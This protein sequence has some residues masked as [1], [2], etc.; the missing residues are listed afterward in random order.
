MRIATICNLPPPFGG[1]E[2][3]AKQLA[4]YLSKEGEEI[5]I[6]TQK[7]FEMELVDGLDIFR[8]PYASEQQFNIAQQGIKIYPLF[9][10]SF[11]RK[12]L[13]ENIETIDEQL[14]QRLEEVFCREKPDV[15][16]CH[17]TTGK[18]KKVLRVCRKM[19]IPL[20][21]TL[22]G[23]TNLVPQYDSYICGG[24]TS[25][26]IL[27]LLKLCTH[28]VVV[29]GQMLDYCRGKGLNNVCR[30]PVGIDTEY[31]SFTNHI[32]RNGILYVGKLNRHK[33]LKETL[34][35]FLKIENLIKEVLYLV[36]RGINMEMFNK[37][38][39][40][41]NLDKKGKIGELLKNGK[42]NLVGELYPPDLR[43]LY[44]R[45]KL[46]VLPSL[47][48]GLPLVILESLSC[49]MPVIA[50]DVGAIPEVIQN[51]K[52]GYL[53]PKGNSDKLAKAILNIC[54]NPLFGLERLCRDSVNGYKINRIVRNYI[55]LFQNVLNRSKKYD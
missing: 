45:S 2:V 48:E 25:E 42:I 43:E 15:A 20:V 37:T 12:F 35:A 28:I 34:E 22:H 50:S 47:T 24:L 4:V 38:D 17:F 49:G 30:I 54:K 55:D 46:L 13:E 29:S 31:F 39:F 10:S 9:V 26:Q 36:G 6:V 16:H 3:F 19:K 11:R 40:F 21:V 7:L 23:M 14:A 8:Y 32:K 18:V 44:R 33:G 27:S 1:A 51:G 41:L 52:N 5:S 53:I